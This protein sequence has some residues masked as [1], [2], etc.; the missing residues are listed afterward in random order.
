MEQQTTQQQVVAMASPQ[1]QEIQLLKIKQDTEF[2]ATP[3][4]QQVKQFEATMRIAKMYAMSSFIPDSYKYK[5]RQ[6]LEDR[7]SVV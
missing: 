2:A 3:V 5:N 7:K 4:G 1:E 6:P